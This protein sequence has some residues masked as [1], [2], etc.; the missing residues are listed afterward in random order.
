MSPSPGEP[1]ALDP[2]AV[3]PAALPLERLLAD[4]DLARTRR[5]G[6]GGQ[7]RNKV[8]TA[9]VVTH[10]PTGLTG[11]AAE[12]RSQDLNR[13]QAI[14]RLRVR[15]AVE[16]RRPVGLDEPASGLWHSRIRGGKLSVNA[17]HAD[18]P[19]LLAEALDRLAAH[20]WDVAVT[21]RVLGVSATQLVKLLKL[22][23]QAL[24]RLNIARAANGLRP[25][26]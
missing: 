18:F 17:E 14:Q 20:E 9:V 21:A 12:R 16:I 25:L 13:Q 2:G 24:A 10:R 19:A 6:P 8:E 23:P 7:H 22:E 11:Q 1:P 4:C 15:L 26:V 5:G 3:H